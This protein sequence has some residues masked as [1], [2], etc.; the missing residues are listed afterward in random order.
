MGYYYTADPENAVP[1]KSWATPKTHIPGSSVK[2]RG[3]RFCLPETGRWLSRDPIEENGGLNLYCVVMNDSVGRMD[4][5][6]LTYNWGTWYFTR[7]KSS[8][9]TLAEINA[10]A[11]RTISLFHEFDMTIKFFDVALDADQT[12]KGLFNWFSY[13]LVKANNRSNVDGVLDFLHGYTISG[14][15]LNRVIHAGAR[16]HVSIFCNSILWSACG[17]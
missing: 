3:H 10:A 11:T 14:H 8:S 2:E 15:K 6:G 16:G 7:P 9:I 5:L 1:P 12:P 13:D 4:P 17:K